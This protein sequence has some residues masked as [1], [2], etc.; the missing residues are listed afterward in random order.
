MFCSLKLRAM[1]NE[2]S[3]KNRKKNLLFSVPLLCANVDAD[4]ITFHMVCH[5]ILS[6]HKFEKGLVI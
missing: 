2:Y 6:V 5:V 1:S 3:K 4:F